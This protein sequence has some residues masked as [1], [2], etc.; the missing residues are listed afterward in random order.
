MNHD[1]P[2]WFEDW[3]IDWGNG[4]GYLNAH[5][6]SVF[7]SNYSQ[8]TVTG[9]Y[10]NVDSSQPPNVSF[11]FPA[12]N[13]WTGLSNP[14]AGPY[15]PTP[16]YHTTNAPNN[17]IYPSIGLD[18]PS[19]ETHDNTFLHIASPSGED[20]ILTQ[21]I[22]SSAWEAGKWYL[23]DI[24]YDE[25][26]NPNTG[27]GGG[28]GSA[29]IYG[30]ASNGGFATNGSG[31]I[32]DP[33]GVGVYSGSASNAHC[34]LVPVTRTEYGSARTVLRGIF[35]FA[36]DSYRNSSQ[37]LRNEFKM[38]FWSCYAG[39]GIRI[40]KIIT[41]KLETSNITGGATDWDRIAGSY[42]N[43]PL[44]AFDKTELYW[45]DNK[46]CWEARQD[47]ISGWQKYKWEQDLGGRVPDITPLGW[48]LNF[49]VSDNPNTED[50]VGNVRGWIAGVDQSD[51]AL[52]EGLYFYNITQVGEYQI[53]FNMNGDANRINLVGTAI[54]WSI[55]KKNSLGN[56]ENWTSAMFMPISSTTTLKT[57]PEWTNKIGFWN[58]YNMTTDMRMGISN[59][60]LTDETVVFQ[61]GSA[62]SWNFD[63]F[64]T[65]THNYIHWNVTNENLVFFDCP[66]IDPHATTSPSELI[67]INQWVDNT[68]PI[69]RYQ[70]YRIEFSYLIDTGKISIYYFNNEGFGFKINN[71]SSS[72]ATTFDQIVQ[73]GEDGD[74]NSAI[75]WSNLNPIDPTYAPD[76]KE[77][78]VIGLYDDSEVVN[79]W[80]DDVSMTRVYDISEQEEKTVTFS[81]DVN[82]WTSFK[83]FVPENGLSLSKKYF[84][85]ED[86]ALYQQYV[87]RV[88]W[89]VGYTD[90]VTG[91][92][93]KY[94]AEEANNYNTFYGNTYNSRITAVLNG[95]PSTIKTF[96]TLNYEGSQAHVMNPTNAS[97]VTINNAQAWVA[98]NDIGGWNCTEIK[99]DLG[100]GSVIE[101]IK[102]EGK[103][104]NYIK[105][106]TVNLNSTPDTSRFS[107]QGLGV[108]SN[109][110]SLTTNSTY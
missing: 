5:Q 64:N 84:T 99:T 60:F 45:K 89:A 70:K 9:Y 109:V 36:S 51:P 3:V 22:A 78:F 56:W 34:R 88:D 73:I 72:T 26:H 4:S 93:I 104:F 102:K 43:V 53:K 19:V 75:K 54:P 108:A 79:G 69:A 21:N 17:P 40:T 68:T 12:P 37:M 74:G 7:G 97:D 80:I 1:N 15:N 92:F 38:K 18:S 58:G 62:G 47:Q 28:N 50:F 101:F 24:E 57:Q 39:S 2:N 25:Q 33:D 86:G 90:S 35:K 46:L 83:S 77:T 6:S 98:S 105:G 48:R 66:A 67:N 52:S 14:G 81:E 44:H 23:V 27:T 91:A 110:T 87:P 59:I 49:K 85:M 42:S 103:W 106:K 8:A 29:H 13:D 63:G 96:N 107:V 71:I 16:W 76:L 11:T 55:E 31:S 65:S 61:G 10:Q 82:G 32:I 41:K 20:V 100:A 95:D 30:V 94:T